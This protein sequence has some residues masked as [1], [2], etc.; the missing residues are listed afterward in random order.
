MDFYVW[1]TTGGIYTIFSPS[2]ALSPNT[3]YGIELQDF[4]TTTGHAQAWLN[5]T[6]IGSVDADLS[7]STPYARLML[8][9]SAPGTIYLDD[10]A[11]SNVYNGTIAPS[12]GANL[13]P[14]SVN[15]G[16]QNVGTTSPAQTVTLT[17]NGSLP[18]SISNIALAGTNATDFAQTN[19]CPIGSNT[20]AS[21]SSCTISVT[22]TPGATGARSASLT[23]TDNAAGSP[24]SV[25][26][27]GTGFTPAPAVS[28]NP[29]SVS[30]G[31]Q[32][33]GSS[34]QAQ[35]VTLTNSGTMPLSISNIA[36]TGA[37]AADYAQTNSCPSGSNTLAAGSSCTIDVTFTP[38]ASGASSAS[39]TGA[40]AT[41]AGDPGR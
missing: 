26:L 14:A 6:S 23:F 17:D 35:T 30:F 36:L 25:A 40:G 10:V 27:S 11:V 8:Y 2:N 41:G 4:Q 5:G 7:T 22:F 32:N 24:Q 31:N 3:W 18:L 34:S 33:V 16:N 37:N 19:T 39:L 1:S 15:F 13:N 29:T 9:D 12:A 21:G 28:L 38:G 20:L